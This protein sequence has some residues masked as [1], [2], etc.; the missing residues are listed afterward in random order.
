MLLD[1]IE[2]EFTLD[3]LYAGQT[4][5]VSVP[6]P[7]GAAGALTR[8]IIAAAFDTAYTRSYGRLL[9][10][11]GRRIVSLRSAVIGRRP[12]TDFS[13]FA[14]PVAG[15]L[16]DAILGERQVWSDGGW[17]LAT[18]YDR[19]ALPRGA[20]ISGPAIIEQPD[21][22]IFIDPGLAGEIDGFGNVI[23]REAVD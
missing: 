5:T 13:V 17:L 18:L 11:I 9:E 20:R 3:M 15:L 1:R 14:A 21:T 8:E 4:H 19:A 22:T 7:L 6:I 16:D 12:A 10:D 2:G 23:I